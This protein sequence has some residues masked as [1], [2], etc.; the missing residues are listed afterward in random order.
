ME[1][2]TRRYTTFLRQVATNLEEY[3]RSQL[4][5]I[6]RIDRI[7]A[8]AKEPEK[9][10]EKASRLDDHGVPKYK[11]PLT[12]IQDQVGARIIV[13]YIDDVPN[14]TKEIL[15]Y[16]QHIENKDV[17]PES[18]WEFGYAGKHLVLVLPKDVVP[19]EVELSQVP[20]F[21]ELQV[22]TLYQHAWSEANHDLGYKPTAPLNTDQ[23]RRLAYTAAQSWG[24]D[25]VFV[26]L[27]RELKDKV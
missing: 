21:F 2:Y 7:T 9:F 14:V 5:H 15:R 12:Q 6:P 11:H 24:A 22:K 1:E 27:F 17:L 20:N 18:E 19:R 13:L 16:F 26:E 3:L 25:R 8:R 4:N 10:A 23:N